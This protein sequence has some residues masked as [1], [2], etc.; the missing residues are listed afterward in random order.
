MKI[1]HSRTEEKNVGIWISTTQQELISKNKNI[2]V[3]WKLSY[4]WQAQKV[5]DT[6]ALTKIN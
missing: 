3:E 1:K 6:I 5:N 4:L 2:P